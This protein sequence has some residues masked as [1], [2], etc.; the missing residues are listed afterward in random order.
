MNK[1]KIMGI[2]VILAS[3]AGLLLGFMIDGCGFISGIQHLLTRGILA[4]IVMAL[5]SQ[6]IIGLR[7]GAWLITKED[8]SK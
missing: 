6:W 1:N 5:I 3:T 2:I 7:Y 8:E 4:L